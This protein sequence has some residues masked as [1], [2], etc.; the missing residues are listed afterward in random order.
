MSIQF[1]KEPLT[2]ILSNKPITPLAATTLFNS[3]P[4]LEATELLGQ[5]DGTCALTN[6]PGITALKAARWVGKTFH[7]TEDVD[8]IISLDD[9]VTYGHHAPGEGRVVNTFM[10]KARIREIKYN[11]VVSAAMVY[12]DKPIIDYFRRVD[13]CTVMGVMDAAGAVEDHPLYFV[14]ERLDEGS[15]KG[16]KL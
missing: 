11:G 10:G 14:L 12:N 16:G 8:P 6:H 2:N 1:N 4:P 3:L 7:T 9:S 5:W 15:S 13:H